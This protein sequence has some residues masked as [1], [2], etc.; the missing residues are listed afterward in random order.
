MLDYEMTPGAAAAPRAS[1]SSDSSLPFD[2][3]RANLV[4]FVHPKCPCSR[5]S[6]D[7]LAEALARVEGRPNCAVVFYKPLGGDAGWEQTDLWRQAGSIPGV[8]RYCDVGGTEAA[9]FAASVSGETFL[10]DRRGRLLFHGGITASRGHRGENAGRTAIERLLGG[11]GEPA[12]RTP[13][14]G[15]SLAERAAAPAPQSTKEG[16][17]R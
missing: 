4:M 10:Y 8:T 2:A 15:C 3:G 11:D 6:L 5:A 12:P 7:E 16:V 14:F 13:V 9:R 1:W 17:Q